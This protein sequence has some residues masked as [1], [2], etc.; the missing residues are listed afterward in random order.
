MPVHL[1][2]DKFGSY[3][4]WG[5]QK[6]YYFATEKQRKVA[7]T[8]AIRQGIAIKGGMQ[9]SLSDSDIHDILKKNNVQASIITYT[10]LAKMDTLKDILGPHQATVICYL[11]KKNYGH[12]CCLFQ[13]QEGVQFFDP[14]GLKPDEELDWDINEYFRKEAGEDYPHLTYLLYKSNLPIHYNQY[15][16]QK[17]K[18]GVA[19]CGRHTI[20]RLVFRV[21]SA[22]QYDELISELC[23]SYKLDPDQ[24][25]T[26]LTPL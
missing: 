12:W 2:R 5:K 16:F 26:L 21:L 1:S 9:I 17:Q 4:Q 3:Y 6:K 19:T 20:V 8:K 18:K 22:E 23:K 14:Y 7:K 11:T 15:D 13:N 25:V 24:L 10:Q